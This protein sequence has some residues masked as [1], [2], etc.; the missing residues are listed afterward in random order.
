MNW[1]FRI[2]TRGTLTL[3]SRGPSPVRFRPAE[4]RGDTE[5]IDLILL[6]FSGVILTY[7]DYEFTRE[8]SL[9]PITAIKRWI[10][11]KTKLLV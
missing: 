2:K 4:I 6:K 8:L 3:K 10:L 1:N 5:D 11:T 7:E 9:S